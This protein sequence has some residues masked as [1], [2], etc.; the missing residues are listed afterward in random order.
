MTAV[1]FS[2][3]AVEATIILKLRKKRESTVSNC[4]VPGNDLKDCILCLINQKGHVESIKTLTAVK[5]RAL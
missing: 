2:W 4:E 5:H 3:L 1:A